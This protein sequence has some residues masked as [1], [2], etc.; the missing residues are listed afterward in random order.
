VDPR[1]DHLAALLDISRP[2]A[3]YE[4][5]KLW[6]TC[7]ETLT[8]KHPT[9]ALNARF[10]SAF[11]DALCSARLADKCGDEVH[12]RGVKERIKFL[13]GNKS[14]S[15]QGGVASGRSRS[16][17]KSL[18]AEAPASSKR[19]ASASKKREPFASK[20]PKPTSLSLDQSPDLDLDHALDLA[21]DPESG[22]PDLG[23]SGS[24]SASAGSASRRKTK[25]R[26]PE[27][28]TPSDSHREF[29]TKHRLDLADQLER[30]RLHFLANGES[31]LRWDLR[32]HTWLRNA[33]DWRKPSGGGFAP[34]Q[35]GT[36][37]FIASVMRESEAL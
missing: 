27:D 13:Q 31:S 23:T 11:V 28:F 8:E 33:L 15:K 34:R 18:S 12:V 22:D 29:A 25:T 19:E 6:L 9:L 4:C 2:A 37:E 26:L 17:N 21:P 35:S 5:L 1:F 32:F 10:G 7:Y 3:V 36:S 24:L 30:F 14:K 20:I 16:K